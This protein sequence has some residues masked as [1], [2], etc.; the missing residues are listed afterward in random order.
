MSADD[1][2]AQVARYLAGEIQLDDLEDWIAQRTWNVHATGNEDCQR[3]AYAIE[4]RLAEH[5]SGH[6]DEA[7]LRK[8]LAPLVTSYTPQLNV[9]WASIMPIE[10]SSDI[11][12]QVGIPFAFALAPTADESPAEALSLL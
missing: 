2:R 12:A 1:I 9:E 8:E 6:L 3:L 4:A 11:I 10:S 7:A 5:S